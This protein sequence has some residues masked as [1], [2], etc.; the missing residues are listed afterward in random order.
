MNPYLEAPGVWESLHHT[1][2]VYTAAALN[3]VLPSLYVAIVEEWLRV[4]PNRQGIRPDVVI[5]D[6]PTPARAD[7]NV[8]TLERNTISG[9]APVIVEAPEAEPHHRFV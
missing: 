1:L 4:I 6:A 5:G 9:D 8:A 2:I 3:R 7:G